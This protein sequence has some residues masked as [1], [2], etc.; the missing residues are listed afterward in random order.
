MQIKIKCFP[1]KRRIILVIKSVRGTEI[2][3]MI[4][5]LIYILSLVFLIPLQSDYQ[6]LLFGHRLQDAT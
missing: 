2:A 6:Y 1:I 3:C 4:F 5:I